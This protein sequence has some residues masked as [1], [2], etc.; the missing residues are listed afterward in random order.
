MLTNEDKRWIAE[1]ISH[2][3]AA[4]EERTAARIEHVETS[5]LTEFH[6]WASPLES[7]QRTHTATLRAIDAEM[8]FLADRVTKLGRQVNAEP[9]CLRDR[10]LPRMDCPQRCYRRWLHCPSNRAQSAREIIDMIGIAL[11]YLAFWIG[12]LCGYLIR[13]SGAF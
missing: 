2:V 9:L 3:I 5:L 12:F 11:A 7:R 1:T 8:E 4:S 13:R 6:K 10:A